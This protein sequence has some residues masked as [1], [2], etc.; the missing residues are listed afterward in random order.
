MQLIGKKEERL[1]DKIPN[2]EVL[3]VADGF[4]RQDITFGEAQTRK[5][6]IRPKIKGG[7]IKM[8]MGNIKG[9]PNNK[10]NRHKLK[11][12]ANLIKGQDIMVVTETATTTDQKM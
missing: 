2:E 4:I 3:I 10:N 8:I 1:L 12:V 9:M 5:I 11:Q 6:L 7:S